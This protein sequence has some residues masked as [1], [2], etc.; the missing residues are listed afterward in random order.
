MNFET[1]VL[2]SELIASIGVVISLIYLAKQVKIS[3]R[4]NSAASRHSLSKF[5]MEITK[6]RAEHADRW[7]KVMNDKNLSPGDLEFRN[8]NH[9]M[10]FLHAETYFHHHK[11]KLMPNN[12][13]SGYE[14]FIKASLNSPGFKDYWNE[15][16]PAFSEDFSKWMDKL[17][18]E[19]NN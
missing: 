12:H 9:M 6:F 11:L 4:V 3:T 15:V 8:W 14:K 2:I 1:I 18:L 7:A 17:F 16:G 10:L 19:L 13:W 5:A